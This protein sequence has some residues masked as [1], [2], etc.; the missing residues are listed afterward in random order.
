GDVLLIIQMQGVQINATN[1][2]TYGDGVNGSGYLNNAQAYAGKMEYLIAT[3][4]VPLSGGTLTLLTAT[5]NNYINTPFGTDGQYTYQVIRVPVYYNLILNADITPPSWDGT[6]GGVVAMA[7]MNT[8]NMNGHTINVTG[9]G[10]RGGGGT[11]LYF[12]DGSGA[13]RD[14][15][16]VSPPDASLPFLRGK[17][18][19]KGEGIAGTPRLINE[20]N[21]NSLQ[22]NIAEGYPG[23]SFGMGSPGNAGGGGTDDNTPNNSNNSGGGGGGNGGAGGTGGNSF[24]SG[25][26]YGGSSGAPF[27]QRSPL[28]LVMGGGGGAGDSN[29]GS[30][31]PGG[32]LASSGAA[33]GGIVII[34][35]RTITNPGFIIANGSNANTTVLNDA[36]G[37]G[38]AGGSVSIYA[39]S[40]HANIV[41]QANGGN[42]GNNTGGGAPHGPGGGGGGGVIFSNGTLHAA[43]SVSGGNPGTT[44]GAINYGALSGAAGV[45]VTGP[46]MTFPPGCMI[47]PMNF[48]SVNGKRNGAQVLINWEVTNEKD[49]TNY[50]IERSNN[51]YDFFTAGLVGNK[52]GNGDISKYTFSDASAGA[53]AAT[54]YRIIAQDADGQKIVSK[55]ITIQTVLSEEANNNMTMFPNPF[56][57]YVSLKVNSRQKAQ[58]RITIYD[59]SGKALK[60]QLN[61]L[62][63]GDN[64][65][66]VSGLQFLSKGTYI[67]TTEN[68]MQTVQYKLIK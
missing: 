20:D 58:L 18:A 37:G 26:P 36:S 31:V 9:A 13:S 57:D 2:I 25:G 47:L 44:F 54:F 39:G 17:H 48:L 3:N 55:V 27:A 40:G 19:S 32:G 6:T 29:D 38:G 65:I 4:S 14:F 62:Y 28:R 15:A 8:L 7:V 45:S 10:F 41:V 24:S 23:G 16:K 33:G 61:D 50:I 46:V 21:Y 11:Q 5:V 56:T 49:V 1:N 34:T 35:A 59:V 43:S 22:K 68:G 52:P 63:P 51:G 53:A 60:N 66:I 42:G 30:G 64:F 12:D 67:L